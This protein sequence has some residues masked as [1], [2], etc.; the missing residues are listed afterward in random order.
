MIKASSQPM[1]WIVIGGV[2]M[3]LFPTPAQAQPSPSGTE[4]FLA[5][6]TQRA[7]R[8]SLAL[9]KNITNR[10]GYDNQ[11][12][13][14]PDGQGI[15]YTL[16]KEDGRADIYRYDLKSGRIHQVTKTAES[17]YSASVTPDGRHFSVVRVELDSTQRLWR[18][19]MSGNKPE[20]VLAGVKPVGYYAWCNP[21]AVALFVLGNPSTLQVS[22]IQTGS[23]QVVSKNIG[24]SI[25]KIPGRNAASFVDKISEREWW[26]SQVDCSTL[27]TTSLIRTLPGSEFHAWM[28]DGTLLMARESKLFAWKPGSEGSWEEIADL[29]AAGIRN[30]TRIAVSPKGNALA[31]VASD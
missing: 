12:S 19:E 2:A 29:S 17:E 26:I 5:R 27:M 14:T 28:S 24:R 3:T 18:F 1:W 15:L 10:P 22:N 4:I 11:P 30:I 20:L 16:I 7:G 8:I 25:Q 13:F 21:A 23:A 31:L 9:P 6:L